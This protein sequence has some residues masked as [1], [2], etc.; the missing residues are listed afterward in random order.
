[1]YKLSINRKVLA[2]IFNKYPGEIAYVIAMKEDHK[3]TPNYSILLWWIFTLWQ[4]KKLEKLE[5]RKYCQFLKMEFLLDFKSL[6]HN[7]AAMWVAE[8]GYHNNL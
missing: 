6:T 7:L 8:K 4:Q 1:M 3:E 5:N 2:R